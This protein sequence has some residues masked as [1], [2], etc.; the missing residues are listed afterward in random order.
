MLLVIGSPTVFK[1]LLLL[2]LI[3]G[4]KVDPH[5][6]IMD[7]TNHASGAMLVPEPEGQE[8][9]SGHSQIRDQ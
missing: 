8:F 9:V 1:S 4:C 2:E 3:E 7:P 6:R 5:E